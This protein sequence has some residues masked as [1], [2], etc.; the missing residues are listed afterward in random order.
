[1]RCAASVDLYTPM[2]MNYLA[3]CTECRS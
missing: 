2:L 3:L 1:V